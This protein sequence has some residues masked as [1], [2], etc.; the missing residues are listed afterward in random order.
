VYHPVFANIPVPPVCKWAGLYAAVC[1]SV[2][3][4]YILFYILTCLLSVCLNLFVTETIETDVLDLC[5]V[6]FINSK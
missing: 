1:V 2:D 3:Y 6:K 5:V 4:R